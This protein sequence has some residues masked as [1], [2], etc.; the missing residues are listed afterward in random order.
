MRKPVWRTDLNISPYF[1]RVFK[2][3]TGMPPGQYREKHKSM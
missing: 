1:V 2:K 3:H